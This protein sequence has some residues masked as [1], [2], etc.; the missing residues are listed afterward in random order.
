MPTE[1]SSLPLLEQRI[2]ALESANRRLR[3]AGSLLL[4]LAV[5]GCLGGAA[6]GAK[7]TQAEASLPG[8]GAVVEADAFVLRDGKGGVA[9]RLEVGEAG[10]RLVLY[11][12]PDKPGVVLQA[13]PF[14]SEIR[15]EANGVPR[16]Q[17]EAS[18]HASIARLSFWDDANRVMLQALTESGLSSVFLL[19]ETNAKGV[20]ANLG[21]VMPPEGE[22]RITMRTADLKVKN[23]GLAD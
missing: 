17:L 8:A 11:G 12:E 4:V 6:V 1:L 18:A 2:D 13:H 5:A 16:V 19:G 20:R 15:M 7:P 21:M 9:A 23:I 3:F 10:P 14:G 22:P